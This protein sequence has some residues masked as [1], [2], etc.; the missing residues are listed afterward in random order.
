MATALLSAQLARAA[1]PVSYSETFDPTR[2]VDCQGFTAIAHY[3]GT[4]PHRLFEDRQ[5][6]SVRIDAE[7]TNLSTGLTLRSTA[8]F[9]ITLGPDDVSVVGVT[10][11]F[12]RPGV[13]LLSISVGRLVMD[14]DTGEAIFDSGPSD[15][16]QICEALA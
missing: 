8:P 3:T 12:Y 4:E 1:E 13:G 2:T 7:Y 14:G 6:T 9:L 16:E 10:W 5:Q 11:R 15:D